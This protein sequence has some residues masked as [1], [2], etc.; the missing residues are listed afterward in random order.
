VL[1]ARKRPTSRTRGSDEPAPSLELRHSVRKNSLRPLIERKLEHRRRIHLTS[2]I[3]DTALAGAV[4]DVERQEIA[5]SVQK[6]LDAQDA[7][8]ALGS[9]NREL[10]EACSQLINKLAAAKKMLRASMSTD[11]IDAA[12]GLSAWVETFSSTMSATQILRAIAKPR[13]RAPMTAYL[14]VSKRLGVLMS[15]SQVKRIFNSRRK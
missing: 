15:E 2:A 1:K 7:K 10:V 5:A 8:S 11:E 9:R 14:V 12:L 13:A 3:V 6:K 4:G